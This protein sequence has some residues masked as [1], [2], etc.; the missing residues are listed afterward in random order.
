MKP[1][2]ARNG[3]VLGLALLIFFGCTS[4]EEKKQ[5]FYEKGRQLFEQKD[6]VQ[7]RLALK[8]AI[9]IDPRF[10]AAY[11]LLGKV[12]L[13][14][15]SVNRAFDYLSKAVTLEPELL[16]AQAVLGQIYLSA[17]QL[18]K[19]N[20]KLAYVMARSPENH[21][22]R[23]LEAG[24]LLAENN[25]VQARAGL[26]KLQKA[27]MTDPQ[28]FAM[29]AVIQIKDGDAT[30]GQE[31][32]KQGIA[33]NPDNIQLHYLLASILART[34]QFDAAVSVMKAAARIEPDHNGHKFKLAELYWEMD[35]KDAVA[36]LFAQMMAEDDDPAAIYLQVVT[37]YT[38]L[39]EWD[40]ALKV[41]N[42]GIQRF[43]QNIKLPLALSSIQM[44]MRQHDQAMQTLTRALALPV[45]DDDPDMIKVKNQLA[46]L[47]LNIGEINTA[48]Q[49]V[50]AVLEVSN[51]N[52]EAQLIAG[53]I[54]LRQKDLVRAISAFR[55]VATERPD[56]VKG[57]LSL[58][59]AHMLNHE[60]RLA[61][62]ALNK[63]LAATK[64][65]RLLYKALAFIYSAD[66]AYEAAEWQLRK[67]A[68]AHED[69]LKA[70]ADLADFLSRRNKAEEAMAI[71]E[72]MIAKHPKVPAGYFK[73][74][75][76][77][78]Q[79]GHP[80]QAVAVLE[81]GHRSLPAVTSL[82]AELV[83]GY[84]AAGMSAKAIQ[85]VQKRIDSDQ[86]DCVAHN[87]LG[88]IY[89]VEKK[90]A[91][92]G[93]QFQKAMA[94]DPQWQLPHNNLSR[95]YLIQGKKAQAAQS[96]NAALD[97]NPRNAAAYLTLGS[98]YQNGGEMEKVMDV[99][100]KALDALPNLWP[101]ANN[102]AFLL[103]SDDSE[104]ESLD[105]AR[106]L[107]LRAVH[108][109]PNR[110]DVIDT[111]GW[112]HYQRGET[113]LAISEYEKAIKKAPDSAMISYHLGLALMQ[114]NR[115]EEAREMLE[116]AA[117]QKDFSEQEAAR[118]ALAK[119]VAG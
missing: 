47:H 18:D 49:Y 34:R 26:V 30:A 116:K 27:G 100:E 7:A 87:L 91:D 78:Q 67:S 45:D 69:D 86:K 60:K 101:A 13:G 61:I 10:A 1:G 46:Q 84:M 106:D 41:V 6:Y 9:Q 50:D 97:Q 76:I 20:E 66:K 79:Q 89:L 104:P 23:L 25:P 88:E 31:T 90:F 32:L 37:F 115:L 74:A 70:A 21:Q 54:Y 92:A 63:G 103:A 82:L 58:A 48:K 29:L 114:V 80:Q 112:V 57:H 28:L 105:R 11:H 119:L 98:L 55:T 59:Q 4:P 113:D 39:K 118:K 43:P 99:Y 85:L 110:P 52:I 12:E 15:K 111:L 65:S 5:L 102:L 56:L 77:Y 8:N 95:V 107:A 109:Q 51:K 108:L 73:L 53:Q 83:H 17:R 44:A 117:S 72:K 93:Q 96:L 2:I 64:Q 94:I 40:R 16:E 71:Y 38:R 14:D 42:A 75:A 3:V 62:D 81:K 19:A 22:G 24:I 35:R 36:Q 68:R 33:A